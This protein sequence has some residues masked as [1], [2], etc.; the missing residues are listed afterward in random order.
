MADKIEVE[1]SELLELLGSKE[2]ELMKAR[3][4]ATLLEKH[5]QQLKD[6]LALATK[7]EGD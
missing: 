4:R 1:L 2:I 3:Q 7:T 6:Q 5:L